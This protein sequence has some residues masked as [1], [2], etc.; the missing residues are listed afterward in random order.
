MLLQA[1]RMAGCFSDFLVRRARPR[2][3][4]SGGVPPPPPLPGG[5]PAAAMPPYPFPPPPP[6]LPPGFEA[7]AADQDA[8]AANEAPNEATAANEAAN[9]AA[10]AADNASD[11][12]AGSDADWASAVDDLFA[13]NL[14]DV[15]ATAQLDRQLCSLL[16]RVR[17]FGELQTCGAR[18]KSRVLAPVKDEAQADHEPDKGAEP[19]AAEPS[20]AEPVS[21]RS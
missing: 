12:A 17:A 9:E 4:S 1:E 8:T 10:N 15:G 18:P 6:G 13:A 2:G 19:G 3:A 16:E 14:G 11:D 20:N 7:A 21:L 5:I